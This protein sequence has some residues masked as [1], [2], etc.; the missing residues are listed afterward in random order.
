MIIE[1]PE[2]GSVEFAFQSIPSLNDADFY[3]RTVEACTANNFLVLEVNGHTVYV[4]NYENG[5]G[6]EYYLTNCRLSV[7]TATWAIFG[8]HPAT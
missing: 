5:A 3:S 1:I 4:C 6:L 8:G 2:I 7:K